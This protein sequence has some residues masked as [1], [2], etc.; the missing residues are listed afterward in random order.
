MHP[1][2]LTFTGLSARLRHGIPGLPAQCGG[3]LASPAASSYGL[4]PI[5]TDPHR[6]STSFAAIVTV[7]GELSI[8]AATPR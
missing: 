1:A 6:T 5:A 7:F 8:D 4:M 3:L 2:G